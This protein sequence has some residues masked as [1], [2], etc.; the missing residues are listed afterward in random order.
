[1]NIFR[2][3]LKD[4]NTCDRFV[5]F[6]V[7]SRSV[8]GGI[9]DPWVTD[10][11][12]CFDQKECGHA[13]SGRVAQREQSP[14][15]RIQIPEAT[16][17]APAVTDTPAQTYLSLTLQ[18]TQQPTLPVRTLAL[19]TKL[20]RSRETTTSSGGH[21]LETGPEAGVNQKQLEENVG[22]TPVIQ[23]IVVSA[24]LTIFLLFG[25]LLYVLCKRRNQSPQYSPGIVNSEALHEGPEFPD[26][27]SFQIAGNPPQADGYEGSLHGGP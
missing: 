6:Q 1:M 20:T 21:N 4:Y 10:L 25:A 23:Y 16:E 12:S 24:L 2:Q 3:R 27:S 8:C 13:S 18:S 7:D 9:G 26:P 5:R 15:A 14:P 11:T 19:D 22:S 17:G